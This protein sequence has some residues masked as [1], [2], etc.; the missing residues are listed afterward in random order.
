[1]PPQT[2]RQMAGV[3]PTVALRP[4]TTA[5][6]LIDFQN[7]YFD[8]RLPLPDGE[9]AAAGAVSLVDWADHVGLAVIHVRHV[10]PLTDSPLFPAD[11]PRSAFHTLLSPRPGHGR[12]N[13]TMPS[14]FAGTALNDLL[15]AKGVDT[16]L[17]CG[18]MTHNCVESTVREAQSLGYR[19]IVVGDACA[20]RELPSPEGG[21]IGH[22]EIHRA[23]LAALADRIAEV[24]DGGAV[25]RLALT[26]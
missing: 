7:E 22:R 26:P 24:M 1:M 9:K 6:I 5:L 2:L 20:A 15:K 16:L 18:L 25:M 8:G 19:T 12:V 14:S 3:L 4:T 10:A 11:S 17:V 23:S 13:K 21:I